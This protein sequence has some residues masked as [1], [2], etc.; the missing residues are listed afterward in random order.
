MLSAITGV[1]A[2][3][4]KTVLGLFQLNLLSSPYIPI[5]GCTQCV[6]RVCVGT[7][8]C[9]V[10][11]TQ[12][13]QIVN[14]ASLSC[15]NACAN[16][17]PITGWFRSRGRTVLVGSRG[18]PACSVKAVCPAGLRAVPAGALLQQPVTS[19]SLRG[20]RDSGAHRAHAHTLVLIGECS[21]TPASR[22]LSRVCAWE[23]ESEAMKKTP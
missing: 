20:R 16:K 19:C 8:F 23:K 7:A 12:M 15:L 11:E 2:M 5:S 3:S 13:F 4:E 6:Y 1:M 18:E 10:W 17:N 22:D 9:A 21:N 14:S